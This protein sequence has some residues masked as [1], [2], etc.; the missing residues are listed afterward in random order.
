M[1]SAPLGEYPRAEVLGQREARVE[2]CQVRA[3]LACLSPSS[4]IARLS[5]LSCSG[6][7]SPFAGLLF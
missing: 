1:P 3:G 7:E 5:H 2:V 6:E 4:A